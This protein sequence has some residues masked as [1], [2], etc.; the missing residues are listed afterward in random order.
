MCAQVI[1][2]CEKLRELKFH[3]IRMIEVRQRPYDAR[4]VS[5]CDNYRIFCETI[6]LASFLTKS[7]SPY[8]ASAED[9]TVVILHLA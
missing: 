9:Y 4:Y 8:T 2:T 3:S 6:M 7:T 1:K 5:T